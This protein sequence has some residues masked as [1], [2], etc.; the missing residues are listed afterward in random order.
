MSAFRRD[1]H[2]ALDSLARPVPALHSRSMA[3]VRAQDARRNERGSRFGWLAGVAAVL[4]AL[5]VVG[6]FQLMNGALVGQKPAHPRVD[7]GVWAEDLTLTGDVRAHVTS[8]VANNGAMKKLKR[9]WT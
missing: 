8:T 3:A 7:S 5:A 6:V 4:L 9:A 2:R 1:V